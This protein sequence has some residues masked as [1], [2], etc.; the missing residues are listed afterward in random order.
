MVALVALAGVAGGARAETLQ[1]ALS[2]AWHNNPRLAAAR[3]GESAAKS[4]VRAAKGEWYPKLGLQAQIAREHTTG[5]ITF[6]NPPSSFDA[7]LNQASL[8]LRLDQPLY[9]GGRI[10]SD[11]SV[12]EN[13]V[14]ASRAQ[15][16]ERGSDVLLNAVKAYLDVFAAQK[17]LAVQQEN[18]GVIGKR[19][20]AAHEALKHGEGTNTDV[21]QAESRLQGAIAARIRAQSELAQMRALY[22]TVVGH[23]PG[24]LAIPTRL[25]RLPATLARAE[26]L[27]NQDYAVRAAEFNARAASDQAKVTGAATMPQL[28][29]FAEV[30]RE[31]EP[32]YGFEQLNDEQIGV[33]LSFPIWR[34]GTLRAK[35]AAAHKRAHQAAL[36]VRAAKDQ[37]QGSVV[38]AW[39]DYAAARAAFGADKSR[40]SAARTA[41]KGV[42]AQHRHGERTLLDVLNAEQETRNAKAALIQARRDR[43]V[44]AYA[45]L[46][47]TGQLSANSLRLAGA[48]RAASKP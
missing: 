19:K 17:L 34:G 42:L 13:K 24:K 36:E 3:A 25:P 22:R 5:K 30:R 18:V 6:F 47:A 33:S 44:A 7:D 38:A 9:Q 11:I 10:S 29:L 21:S 8:A 28:G 31:R 45:L 23:A 4:D 20:Q 39:H 26:T 27:A 2:D 12:A 46:A 41:Y 40:L 37:A 43:I 1:Q 32:Q 48:D 16:G 35:S 15:T 14:S